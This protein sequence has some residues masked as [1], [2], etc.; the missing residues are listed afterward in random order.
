MSYVSIKK[1]NYTEFI[2]YVEV[3]H[4]PSIKMPTCMCVSI[5]LLNF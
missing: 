1:L 5:W 2:L 4:N 3:I